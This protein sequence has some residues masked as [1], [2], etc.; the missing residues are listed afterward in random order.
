MN[1]I[2]RFSGEPIYQ[3]IAKDLKQKI[4]S[5]EWPPGT[6]IP[7]ENDLAAFYQ[8]SRVTIR[9][10]LE[11]LFRQGLI[12]R[13]PGRGT[14]V[15]ESVFI[16]EP[17]V[18]N[19]FSSEL[20]LMGYEPSSIIIKQEIEKA[21][22]KI[23]KHLG[24]QVGDNVI[25]LRR[26]RK[27]NNLIVCVQTAWLPARLFPGL[28][29]V[30]LMDKS[31]YEHLEK[32]YQLIP[33]E[34]NEVFSVSHVTPEDAKLLDIPLQTCVFIQERVSYANNIPFEF[35][36]GVFRGDRYKVQLSVSLRKV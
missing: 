5:G 19:S 6:K 14:F 30:D 3:Q 33:E 8:T 17:R 9:K 29:K 28:E 10:S 23:A 32:Y 16:G 36:L 24:I 7:G 20:R 18:F 1:T 15:I 26:I 13:E 34:A 27:G 25:C 4:S 22:P 21:E 12:Q 11:F 35:V 31:L 2:S